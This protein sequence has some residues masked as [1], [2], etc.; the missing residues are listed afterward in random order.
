[1]EP[2]TLTTDRF[3]LRP[4][5]PDDAEAVCRIC[6]DPDIQ[7]WTTV[8]SPYLREHAE[9]FTGH[10]V[11]EGW[12]NGTMYTFAVLPREGG[13]L[14]ASVS[15]TLRTYS[16]TWEIGFWTAAEFRGRGI[17]TEVVGALAHWAFT[18]LRA[19]RLEWRA[20][21]GNTASRAVAGKAGFT[22]EGTLRAALLNNGTLRDTWVASIL[23][24]DLGLT[25][26]YAHLPASVA[27]PAESRDKHGRPGT[28]PGRD[29]SAA[30]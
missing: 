15:V 25:S 18:R 7:R 30:V 14:M 11:P 29:V 22:M 10:T 19:T 2:I 16:G 17:M 1:M 12:H 20:E 26:D 28:G 23:P 8:P 5:I 3:L 4:F 21:V 13:P 27:A 9:E 24:A 6:Q